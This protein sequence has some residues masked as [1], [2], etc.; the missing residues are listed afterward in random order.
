MPEISNAEFL[1]KTIVDESGS[2]ATYSSHATS[3]GQIFYGLTS[4][5]A[6]DIASIAV[7]NANPW[8]QGD[9]LRTQ[10]RRSRAT[11][12]SRCSRTPVSPITAGPARR[13]TQPIRTTYDSPLLRRLDWV[14]ARDEFITVVG[15]NNDGSNAALLSSS[16]NAIAVGRS[17]GGHATGTTV[18]GLAPYDDDLYR[19]Q[20]KARSRGS[21]V[22]HEP[23]D[24]NGLGRCGHA[25]SARKC[26]MRPC[27]RTRYP[28]PRPTGRAIWYGMRNASKSSRRHSWPGRSAPR[29]AMWRRPTLRIT[30]PRPGTRPAMGSTGGLVLASSTSRTATTSSR[31]VRRTASRTTARAAARPGSAAL[32][33][34][35]DSAGPPARTTISRPTI[36]RFRPRTRRSPS[37]WSGT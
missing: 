28:S 30:A 3:V 9:F 18:V 7:Y 31:P 13:P 17:D 32:T 10:C 20:G 29:A 2:P 15:L 4:S 37:P 27:R 19:R 8:W 26:A 14:I 11:A 35:P 36:S 12:R 22:R 34:T 24:A 6:K 23:R 25:G 33:T 1:G 16:F 5:T 21:C